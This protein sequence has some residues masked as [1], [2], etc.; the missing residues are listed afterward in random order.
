MN[1]NEWMETVLREVRF[2]PDRKRIRQELLEHMEDRMEEYLDAMGAYGDSDDGPDFDEALK[3]AEGRLMDSM[4]DPV[5]LGRELNQQHKPWLGW[6]WMASRVLLRVSVCLVVSM[7]VLLGI[8]TPGETA[9]KINLEETYAQMAKY[10]DP[11]YNQSGNI[12]YCLEPNYT[13]QLLDTEITFR[14]L[15]YDDSDGRLDLLVTSCGTANLKNTALEFQCNGEKPTMAQ[16]ETGGDSQG[17]LLEVSKLTY[18]RFDRDA[19]TLQIT[20]DKF[21]EHFEFTVDIASG[22]VTAG[23][24]GA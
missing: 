2:T 14:L 7:A 21:G 15:A 18:E 8:T 24:V 19:E 17:N 4:G 12:Y 22:V 9:E 20:Y 23:E 5:K 3:K 16:H 11:D 10:Y 13:V 6:L 1:R